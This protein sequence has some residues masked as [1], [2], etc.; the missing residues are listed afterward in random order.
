MKSS[1]LQ[2]KVKRKYIYDHSSN[3][4]D[5]NGLIQVGGSHRLFLLPPSLLGLV[6]EENPNIVLLDGGA[7]LFLNDS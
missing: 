4:D 2:R 1:K 3:E 5:E 7:G 6:C